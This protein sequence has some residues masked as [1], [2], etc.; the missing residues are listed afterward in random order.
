MIEKL[1]EAMGAYMMTLSPLL[2]GVS[3]LVKGFCEEDVRIEGEKK[4]L[5]RTDITTA[6]ALRFIEEK[7]RLAMMLDNSFSGLQ[8]LF[9]ED[10]SIAVSNSGIIMSPI[11]KDGRNIGSL[12]IVGPL[13]IDY[14][15]FIPY[16]EYL[17]GRITDMISENDDENG[18]GS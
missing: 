2:K 6:E 17:T 14:A 10:G 16:I 18:G 11:R 3:D 9:G 13:R 15:R 5:A 1:S 4:L 12:G 8:V 7:E